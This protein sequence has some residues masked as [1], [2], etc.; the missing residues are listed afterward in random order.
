[1]AERIEEEQRQVVFHSL[2][3]ERLVN[4][5]RLTINWQ[6]ESKRSTERSSFTSVFKERLLKIIEVEQ[7][8][9]VFYFLFYGAAGLIRLTVNGQRE[10]KRRRDRSSFTSLFKE[11]LVYLG[12]LLK[13]IEEEH[14]QVVFTS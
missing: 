2:F 3:K 8:Q 11:R 6:R 7:R 4:L 5:R 13:R 10:S 1:M 12:S 9:V 14:R